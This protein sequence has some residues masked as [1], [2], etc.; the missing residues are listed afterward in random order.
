[1][2]DK[3]FYESKKKHIFSYVAGSAIGT[4]ADEVIEKY[5]V[6]CISIFEEITVSLKHLSLKVPSCVQVKCVL[7]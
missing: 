5:F 1:M 2:Y 4:Y 6:S 3:S 7:L